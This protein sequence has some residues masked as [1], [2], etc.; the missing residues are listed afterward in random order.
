MSPLP[1][2]SESIT[3]LVALV[4]F[5]TTSATAQEALPENLGLSPVPATEMSEAGKTPS[6]DTGLLLGVCGVGNERPWQVTKFCLGGLVDLLF[7]RDTEDKAGLGGYAQVSSAGFVDIRTSG[8]IT[9]AISLIDWF[10]LSLRGGGMAVMSPRGAQ[11]GIEGYLGLGHRSISLRSHYALSH[12][13]FGGMQ[14]A[15][16]SGSLPASHAIWAGLRID[17]VWL[18]APIGLFR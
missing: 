10:S 11:P 15:L 8:G 2:F 9:S 5:S 7:L 18:T 12:S 17:G 1:A 14:Y 16:P 3:C 4:L 6:W 13:F